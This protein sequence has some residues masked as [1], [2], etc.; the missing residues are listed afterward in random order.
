M[1]KLFSSIFNVLL[2]NKFSTKYMQI[3]VILAKVI[4]W[5]IGLVLLMSYFIE[6]AYACSNPDNFTCTADEV[7]ETARFLLDQKDA[8]L[9]ERLGKSKHVILGETPFWKDY[10]DASE[11]KKDIIREFVKNNPDKVAK[12]VTYNEGMRIYGLTLNTK[13]TDAMQDW[14]NRK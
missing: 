2:G 11:F 9:S 14:A 4:M 6:D 10:D 12:S 8:V 13:L 5:I 7:R 1:E 3:L